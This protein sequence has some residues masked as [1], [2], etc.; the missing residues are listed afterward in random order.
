MILF[1]LVLANAKDKIP[2]LTRK[3]T[4]E[5][6]RNRIRYMNL[7]ESKVLNRINDFQAQELA[8]FELELDPKDIV[9]YV[10]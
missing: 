10:F 3:F 9:L 8:K 7:Y 1:L 4:E 2:K 5:R 6:R